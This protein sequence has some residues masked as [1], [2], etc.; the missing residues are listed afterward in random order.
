M[1]GILK[2]FLLTVAIFRREAGVERTFG[3]SV[4]LTLF[5]SLLE[6][7]FFGSKVDC[8]LKE[9]MLPDSYRSPN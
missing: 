7:S 3:F 4:L 6:L 2:E 1:A 8:N 9:V 5:F